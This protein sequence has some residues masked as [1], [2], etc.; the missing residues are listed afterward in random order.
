V[1]NNKG[2]VFLGDR[3]KLLMEMQEV[4]II[5]DYYLKKAN[6]QQAEFIKST[7][8]NTHFF[9]L[10]YELIKSDEDNNVTYIHAEDFEDWNYWIVEHNES[11]ARFN[12][13]LALLL[14]HS[15]LFSLFEKLGKTGRVFQ[16]YSYSNFIAENTPR[17]DF[18]FKEISQNDIN[19]IQEIYN[20]LEQFNKVEYT[21]ID[22]ALLD[23]YQLR[24]IPSR[25]PFY[26]LGMFS[27]LEA[28]LVHKSNVVSITHQIKTK[29]NLLNNRFEDP[30]NFSE[31]FGNVKYEKVIGKLYEYRSDIAHGDFSDFNGD[32]N[33]LVDF[34]H[35]SKVIH[36]IL[37]TT[38]KQALKEPQLLKDLKNC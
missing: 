19:E 11:R 28:L 13:K 4:Q 35:V 6:R 29:L 31:F 7:S 8:G 38:L 37:K 21:Y 34:D 5:Q 10:N 16:Q 25:S 17:S 27:I 1:T 22:K 14:S 24:I 2:F 26:I 18:E 15:D 32:L 9:E 12:I 36:K 33:V 23:Y 3:L 30:I 20:L